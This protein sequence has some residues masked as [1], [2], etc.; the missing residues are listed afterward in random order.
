[1][2]IIPSLEKL[3]REF[4][5]MPGIGTRTAERLA[6]YILRISKDE[7]FS[8]IEA[9]RNIKEKVIFCKN[10]FNITEVN[11][12]SICCDAK[13]DASLLCVVEEPHDLISIEKTG[14]FRGY[15]HVLLGRLSPLKGIGPDDIKIKEFLSRL[16][17]SA[18]KEVI[19]A[20]NP[21]TEGEATA[22]YISNI[23]K[24][25]QIKISR[26][27]SGIPMGGHLEYVDELTLGKA[28]EGRREV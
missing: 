12:C 18:V 7:A 1:M 14:L 24:P 8:L 27:A 23:I 26:I 16:Q 11:P 25:L 21:N 20:T 4:K 19:I 5:K 13:R 22:I 10:C 3:T 17:N 28:L 15:Y 6:F 2:H 9:I